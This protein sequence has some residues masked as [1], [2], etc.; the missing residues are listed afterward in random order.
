MNVVHLLASP[1]VG[2][3]ER[4]ALGLARHLPATTRTT[5]LSFAERGLARP[6]LDEARRQGFEAIELRENAP[7]FF[8]AAAEVAGHLGRTGADLL[9]C[10]GYK[11]DVVGWLA[12]RRVGV[13]VVAVAHGWTAATL[14][15]QLNEAIDRWVLR[16]MDCTVCVSEAM[17]VKVRR[18][19]V[20]PERVAVIRNAI[21]SAPFDR[22][23]PAYCEMLRSLF[24]EPRVWIVAAAGRLSREKGFDQLVEAAYLVTKAESSAGFVLFGEGPQ[25]EILTRQIAELGLE[26]H[27][28]LGGFRTDV[29]RLLPFV[30]AVVNS[31]YTEGLPVIVLEAMAA[32]VPVVATAVGGTPEVI[33]DGVEGYLVQ[34]GDP[35]ALADRILRVLRSGVGRKMGSRG[36]QR[37]REQFTFAAQASQYQQLFDRLL[38]RPPVSDPTRNNELTGM[39]VRNVVHT[40]NA[41]KG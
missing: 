38:H 28:V 32:A 22:A 40:G 41:E 5:F 9:L 10:S 39:L 1:F 34:A 26:R 21:D 4:Q 14:K 25:R 18:A 33:E 7:R 37:V 35:A 36:Q 30:D 11:P 6:F 20:K 8:R 12:A 19:G 3:P 29:Q 17:A 16:R 31:S 15:V 23:D 2:G 27:F 24:A 13:P